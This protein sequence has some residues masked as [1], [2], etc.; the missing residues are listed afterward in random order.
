[1][2]A[3]PR[4]RPSK[5]ASFREDYLEFWF[6]ASDDLKFTL[7]TPTQSSCWV[8]RTKTQDN[9]RDP[10]STMS[11]YLSLTRFHTDNGDS[12]LFVLVRDNQGAALMQAGEW[13]LEIQGNAVFSDGTVHGWVERDDARAVHFKTGSANELTLSIPGTARTVISVG[14]CQPADPLRLSPSSSR[15]PTRD[16]RRKPELVAPGVDI[17]AAQAGTANGLMAMTGTSM[18]APHVT[19]AVALLLARRARNGHPQLNA[20]Q[21]KAALSQCLRNFNGRWQPGF[22][23]GALDVDLLLNAFD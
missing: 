3:M 7:V 14:A 1:M 12:R 10:N 18:A 9:V 8:D 5:A 22:G 23:H 19:G 17:V 16:D 20:A 13:R 11:A 21:I 6:R 15:G 2:T 4:S